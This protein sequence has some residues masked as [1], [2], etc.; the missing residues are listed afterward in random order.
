MM[1]F[2]DDVW[3]DAVKQTQATV[4]HVRQ[5]SPVSRRPFVKWAPC[6]MGACELE[7]Y[8]HLHGPC[9]LIVVAT[10]NGA[11][12]ARPRIDQFPARRT[13]IAD[14][15]RIVRAAEIR[16][17]IAS[18]DDGCI[19]HV[20]QVDAQLDESSLGQPDVRAIARSSTL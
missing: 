13:E 16:G 3:G 14:R 18:R 1:H 19:P 2:Q 8:L 15:D 4:S 6:A 12:R 20:E 10:P 11:T 5:A 9:R 17:R 7:A